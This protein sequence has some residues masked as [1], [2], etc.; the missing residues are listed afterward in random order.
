MNNTDTIEKLFHKFQSYSA[1]PIRLVIG[2][3]LIIGTQDNVLSWER[4]LEFESFL[5][6]Q[7]MPFPLLSAI[8]SVYAQFI[9]GILFIVGWKTR[10]AALIMITNFIVAILLVHIGDSYQG[11]F[12]AIMM[13]A[14]SIFLLLNGS[15]KLSFDD[16]RRAQ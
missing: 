7:G 13:L 16:R 9:S 14:G 4:M 1:L 12:P 5:T 6:L 2:V 8:L 15:G 10:W 11:T 3:H